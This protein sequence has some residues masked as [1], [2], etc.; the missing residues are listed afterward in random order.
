MPIKQTLEKEGYPFKSKGH[1]EFVDRY[2]RSG[3]TKS[4][5]Q[6]LGESTDKEP[7][8]SFKSCP[9]SLK[10]QFTDE[11][12]MPISDKCCLRLKEEPIHKWSAENHK[13]YGILGIM[14]S[15]GGRRIGAVCLAFNGDKLKNF[16]PLVPI[17]KEWEEWFIDK[18]KVD[19]CEIY[20]PPYNFVRTGCKGCPFA[21]KL[22]DELEVLEKFFPA[23]RKQCEF[24]WKPVYEEYRRIGYRLKPL[25][26]GRQMSLEEFAED[27][28]IQ[29][30]HSADE[31]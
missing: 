10:Y 22:Q 21:I 2:Q 27:E 28:E 11:F 5:I 16:Q 3:K 29:T 23:E 8:S 31:V 9:K 19:I 7:W 6:Y 4:V 18:Y 13:P 15:E 24:I 25:E 14:A 1:S 17:T 30:E 26:N 12:K 20:K